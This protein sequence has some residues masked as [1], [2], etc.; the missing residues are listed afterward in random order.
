MKGVIVNCLAE[1]VKENFDADRWAMAL[2][3]AGLDRKAIFFTTQ[4]I[5]DEICMRLIDS[6]CQVLG[7]SLEQAGDA[8]GDYWVNVFAPR[9][10]HVYYESAHSAQEFLLKMDYIHRIST[11]AIPGSRPPRFEYEW[12]DDRTLRMKYISQ[13][14]LIDLLLGLVKGVGKYYGQELDVIKLGDDLIEIVFS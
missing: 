14:G 5:D 10:Y 13:R 8:F 7:I 9:I 1:M 11:R 12:K 4:D 3:R 2:E 6:V